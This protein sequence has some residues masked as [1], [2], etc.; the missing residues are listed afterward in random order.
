MIGV[1]RTFITFIRRRRLPIMRQTQAADSGLVCLAMIASYWHR[2][3]VNTLYRRLA[4]P[5]TGSTLRGIIREAE[6]LHLSCRP[7]RFEL[8]DIRLLTL[9]AIL[10]WD[11]THFVVLRSVNRGGIIVHDPAVGE[12][13]MSLGEACRHMTGVAVEL[14]PVR[15]L[16]I[17]LVESCRS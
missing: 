10:H 5:T 17:I 1:V 7:V 14:W 4:V 16:P 13:R 8:S 9:P 12:R 2:V 15:F 11:M 6:H 3:D